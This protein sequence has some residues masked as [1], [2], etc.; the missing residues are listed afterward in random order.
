M[1]KT[2]I[3]FTILTVSHLSLI[4]QTI[5]S[6][7]YADI[8]FW[9]SQVQPFKGAV[10][11]D[12]EEAMERI[13]LRL[14]YD[15]LNRVVQANVMIGEYYKAF[16]GFSKLYIDAP[17]IKVKH[18]DGREVHTFFD[19]YGKPI[20]VM[21]GV[22][23]KVF[24]KDEQGR[25]VSLRF[26]DKEGNPATDYFGFARYTWLHAFDGSIIE[27][28]FDLEGD[29]GPLRAGF[30]FMRTRIVYGQD[31]YP[32]LLQNIDESGALVNS[33]SGAATFKYYY[34]QQG[35]FNRWEVY[36]K[37]GNS[38]IG[39][40]NTAGEQNIHDGYY[41]K[42][43]RFFDKEGAPALHWSGAEKWVQEYDRFGN[44]T[45]RAFHKADDT[46]MNRNGGYQQQRYTWSEDGRWLMSEYFLD[47]DGKPVNHPRT[48]IAKTEYVRDENGEIIETLE[49][50]YEGGAYLVLDQ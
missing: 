32:H 13:H 2:I 39:P 30:H 1:K 50:H 25:N 26:V 16:Q 43:I 22:F 7:Y 3:A 33:E 35:R 20:R 36:D 41:L 24:E 17:L 21:N 49:Y 11:L 44:R 31:G 34:D 40:S 5:R 18:E 6:E 38:A 37:D 9:E 47:V 48:S 15:S 42:E 27:E 45:E 28:R 8:P 19:H 4:G 23:Q 14:D 12:K 29:P 46:P 10:P